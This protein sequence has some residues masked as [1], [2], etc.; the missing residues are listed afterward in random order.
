MML[1]CIQAEAKCLPT[2]GMVPGLQVLDTTTGQW[3]T[4]EPIQDALV[5]NVGA[6]AQVTLPI[7]AVV[8]AQTL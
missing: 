3:R 6:Q 1:S 7:S 2:Q 4:V 5:I 8:E